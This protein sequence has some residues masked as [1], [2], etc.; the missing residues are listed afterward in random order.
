MR[1]QITPMGA[2][3]M[4]KADAWRKRPA[5]LRYMAFK[6]QVR[7]SG[8]ILEPGQSIIFLIPMPKSW[9]KRKRALMNETYHTQKPDLDN[10][11]KAVMDSIF[12][13]DAHISH[14]GKLVKLWSEDGAIDIF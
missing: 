4:N 2:V 7:A 10:L 3:R 5:V 14:L 1:Y 6:D 8:M 9:S 11:L 13:D 12:I